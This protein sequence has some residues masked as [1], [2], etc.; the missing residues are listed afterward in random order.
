MATTADLQ[1]QAMD[2][3]RSKCQVDLLEGFAGNAHCTFR[4][5]QF[6]LV[7][8]QPAD[9]RYDWALDTDLGMAVWRHAVERWRPLLVIMDISCTPWTRLVN[10]NYGHRPE[11]LQEMRDHDMP[12]I[13]MCA[14]TAVQQASSGR[15]F[16]MP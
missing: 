13:E 10:T 7:A 2:R 4:A 14:E 12:T 3:R 1:R 8:L 9:Y 16:L 6:D 5:P 11:E 15:L